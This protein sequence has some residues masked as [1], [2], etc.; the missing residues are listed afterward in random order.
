MRDFD[1]SICERGVR[2][3]EE[4]RA[5]RRHQKLEGMQSYRSRPILSEKSWLFSSDKGVVTMV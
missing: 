2:P 5:P 4:E 1:R 3:K